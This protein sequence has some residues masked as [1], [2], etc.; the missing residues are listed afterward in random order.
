MPIYSL[1]RLIKYS[2]KCEKYLIFTRL[3]SD[4]FD[5]LLFIVNNLGKTKF[6]QGRFQYKQIAIKQ[7]ESIND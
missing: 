4:L 7:Y 3:L 6:R 1:C 2:C 5:I